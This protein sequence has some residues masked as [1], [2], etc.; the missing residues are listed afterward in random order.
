MWENAL[1][2]IPNT[3][4]EDALP[5]T[6]GQSL[7]VHTEE[8]GFP[9]LREVRIA[10]IGVPE[11]RGSSEQRG[12][13]D[14]SRAVR[15]ELYALFPGSWDFKV[16]DLGDILPGRDTIDSMTALEELCVEVL[17]CQ[18]IPFVL[19]GSSDLSLAIYR[20]YSHLEQMVNVAVAHSRIALGQDSD[21]L[22]DQNVLSHMLTA[23]PYSLYNLSHIGHQAYYVAPEVLD[24]FERMHFHAH[25]LG[26]I[27][28]QVQE[29]EP[30]VRDA[31]LLLVNNHVLRMADGPGQ[32]HPSPNGLTAE[33]LC[34]MLRYAGM[35]DKL[36]AIGYF[37]Y[38]PQL[39]PT[40]QNA[41]LIAQAF[42]YFLEGVQW[43]KGDYPMRSK[44]DYTRFTVLLESQSQELIFYKSPFSGRWWMEVPSH[45][46]QD[47]RQHLMPC[48]SRDY[49]AAQQ[50]EIPDRW[51][52][53][54]HKAL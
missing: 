42:W 1:Q 25:R 39:D 5:G 47:A 19:G 37:D 10:F 45:P 18:C 24:L 20:A 26:E 35:S 14:A 51:W 21:P 49:E 43:R 7:I 30:L 23:K 54:V 2:P 11:D 9:D 6:L 13:R 41:R 53:A 50:G 17:K 48:S 27:R 3:W 34:A 8:R 12:V 36:T 32:S 38:N 15:K 46:G 28:G 44:T 52:K 4:L 16:A 31:D 29:I 22:S 33:E 40:G